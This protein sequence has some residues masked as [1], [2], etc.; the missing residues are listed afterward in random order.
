[1]HYP[2]A[3]HRTDYFTVYRDGPWK[4]IYH[5]VPGKASDGA[6]YQ[7][8]HLAEDPYEQRDLA[9]ERPAELRRLMQGMITALERHGALYPRD[10]AS[11]SA[12]R[13][14]LP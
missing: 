14:R 8:F 11:G 10:P 4:V 1:M 12:L 2:H 13:P 7:L 6:P 9:R 5:Y 3:P